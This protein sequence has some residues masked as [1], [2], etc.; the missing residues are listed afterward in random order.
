MS[1]YV[2]VAALGPPAPP[3]DPAE[4]S[5][6]IVEE[7]KD[8]WRQVLR[9]V[10]PDRPDLI[11]VGECCDQPAFDL[12]PEQLTQR[13]MEYYE[14]RGDQF[15]TFFS[16]IA[17]ENNCY[18]A[19]SAFRRM[20]TKDARN[21]TVLFDRQGKEV[22]A[23]HKNHVVPAELDDYGVLYGKDAPLLECDFGTIGCA[24][25]F[26]LNYDE[27]RLKYVRSRPDLIVFC[28]MYHGGF[29]Q[30]YWAYS[31]RAHFLGAIRRC[32]CQVY[33]PVGDV[34]ASSTNYRCY[35]S[36]TI[37]LDCDVV[38]YDYHHEALLAMKEKYGAAVTIYDPGYL[39]SVLI[40]SESP[41]FT[42]GDLIAEYEM[43]PLDVYFDACRAHR[44]RPGSVEP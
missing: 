1:N 21:A 36:T 9:P 30:R 34:V 11:A 15:E 23:Y 24:I 43:R 16:E 6:A 41:D 5:Q 31:C 2:K 39:G 10:L 12:P 8:Y 17:R 29:M 40:S 27:L 42:V 20:G 22:G 35:V 7:M 26:D 19:C 28:S 13:L 33:N 25:C 44:A 18:V 3:A 32:P 4:D 38:H 37:N 14:V